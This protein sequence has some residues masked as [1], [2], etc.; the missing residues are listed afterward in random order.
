MISI[1]FDIN[2]T[3]TQA[4]VRA[5]FNALNRD[6]CEVIVWSTFGIQYCRQ[7]CDKY[8]LTPDDIL[9]KQSRYVDVAIDDVPTSISQAEVVVGV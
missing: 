6:K 9:E 2:G 4:R 8:S 3:L 1:A 7:F 5:L